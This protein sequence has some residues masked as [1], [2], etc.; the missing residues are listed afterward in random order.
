MQWCHATNANKCRHLPFSRHAIDAVCLHWQA[1][2]N[3]ARVHKAVKITAKGQLSWSE[4]HCD[5]FYSCSC[6][7]LDFCRFGFRLCWWGFCAGMLPCTA[8]HWFKLSLHTKVPTDRLS[9]VRMSPVGLGLKKTNKAFVSHPA[10][11]GK[12]V[13]PILI[14][15]RVAEGGCHVIKALGLF[16]WWCKSING[17]VQA[18]MKP[19]G[20]MEEDC[21]FGICFM[22][23]LSQIGLI[24]RIN[25]MQ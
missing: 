18:L 16:V 2:Q 7:G 15:E 10:N 9:Q 14:L 11:L 8:M 23:F 3:L 21:N 25:S 5:A 24:F 19:I 17:L 13:S 6:R 20:P 12:G 1:V 4:I 22:Q